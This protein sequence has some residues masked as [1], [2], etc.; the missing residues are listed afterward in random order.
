MQVFKNKNYNSKQDLLDALTRH[1]LSSLKVEI[2]QIKDGQYFCKTKLGEFILLLKDSE[3]QLDSNS[4]TFDADLPLS[5]MYWEWDKISA[6]IIGLVVLLKGRVD[7]QVADDFK[8]NVQKETDM[9]SQQKKPQV[10]PAGQHTPLSQPLPKPVQYG[11]SV[12][13]ASVNITP[14]FEIGRSDLEPNFKGINSGGGMIVGP[15]H[16]MFT[17]PG[18]P[19]GNTGFP[20]NYPGS[21][22]PPNLGNHKVIDPIRPQMDPF[23]DNPYKAPYGGEI[24]GVGTPFGG[25]PYQGGIPQP[26]PYQPNPY[27]PENP[28][29]PDPN[30]PMQL[31]PGSVPHG[32]RFDPITP[33]DKKPNPSGDPDNDYEH[34]EEYI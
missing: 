16:P 11:V 33:F 32:A 3:Y 31:P 14:K 4:F 30:N 22:F 20:G 28:Y 2:K 5:S 8:A 18:V 26:N 27:L 15:D 7:Q 24:G 23:S 12:T 6:I 29:K 21:A 1:T 17:S 9:F 13:V 19:A 25:I 34:P 10:A